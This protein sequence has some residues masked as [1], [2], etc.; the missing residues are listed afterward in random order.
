MP[1]N[2]CHPI[3]LSGQQVVRLWEMW[4]DE[5]VRLYDIGQELGVSVSWLSKN[6]TR[7]GLPKRPRQPPPDKVIVDP[8]PEEIAERCAEMRQKRLA[9]YEQDGV[10]KGTPYFPRCYSWNGQAFG[11]ATP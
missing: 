11:A 9:A 5:S 3:K 2:G 4:H 8:T 10:G 7:F 6:R 1:S